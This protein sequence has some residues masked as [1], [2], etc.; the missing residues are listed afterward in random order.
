MNRV[1]IPPI[2]GG[3][4]EGTSEAAQPANT[5]ID[6]ENVRGIDARSGRLMW[7]AQRPGLERTGEESVGSGEFPTH[8]FE[9]ER[10]ELRERW[11]NLTTTPAADTDPDSVSF[12]WDGPG[13]SLG[14][15]AV[16]DMTSGLEGMGYYLLDTGEVVLVNA[17]GAVSERVPGYVPVGMRP[18]PR[19]AVDTEG[20]IFLAA[21][22]DEALIE[23]EYEG[24]ASLV[25]RITKD[26][27]DIWSQVWETRFESRMGLFGYADGQM[28]LVLDAPE[29][30]EGD[31]PP[32]ELVR[33]A[34]PLATGSVAWRQGPV[35]RPVLDVTIGRG[36]SCLLSCPSSPLRVGPD[37][38]EFTVRTV[39]W[40]PWELPVP[41]DQLYAWV[42]A[43]AVNDSLNPPEDGAAVTVMNDRRKLANPFVEIGGPDRDMRRPVGLIFDAPVWDATAFG[44]LGGVKFSPN[45]ALRSGRNVDETI[46]GQRALIPAGDGWGF[47]AVVQLDEA[48]IAGAAPPYGLMRQAT[49][50]AGQ[51]SLL[52][53]QNGDQLT[54]GDDA[55][56][57]STSVADVGTASAGGSRAAIISLHFP[58]AGG[59]PAWRING[60]AML[61]GAAWPNGAPF[62]PYSVG[63]VTAATVPGPQTV[64]GEG[65][66]N[67]RDLVKL[68]QCTLSASASTQGS[69]SNVRD[70]NVGTHVFLNGD[71]VTAYPYILV[72]LTSSA[73]NAEGIDTIDL[74]TDASAV[75]VICSLDGDAPTGSPPAPMSATFDMEFALNES[76][77]RV[78]HGHNQGYGYNLRLPSTGIPVN[79]RY[80]LLRFTPRNSFFTR[81]GTVGVR[82]QSLNVGTSPATWTFWGACVLTTGSIGN[83][84]RIEGYF[85]RKVGLL[86]ELTAYAPTHPYRDGQPWPAAGGEIVDPGAVREA[87]RSPFPLL[88]KWGADGSPVAAEVSAGVGLGAVM[89]PTGEAVLTVGEPDPLTPGT[90]PNHGVMARKLTDEGRSFANVWGITAGTEI[91]LVATTRLTTG[92]CGSLFFPFRPGP[93]STGSAAV[94]RYTSAG[95]L[96]WSLAAPLLPIALAPGGLLIDESAL[97][98]A[99]G[100]EFLFA[101]T[102]GGP[103]A[104]RVEVTGRVDTGVPDAVIVSRLAVTSAGLIRRL[105]ADGSTWSTVPGGT[106]TGPRPWSERIYGL[107]VLGDGRRYLVYDEANDTLRD[108]SASVKGYLPPRAKLALAHR[109]RLYLAAADNPFALYASRYGDVFDWDLGPIVEDVAQAVAG[110]TSSQGAVP[111]RI[112]A[113][114]PLTDDVMLVGT[115]RSLYALTGDLGEGGRLDLVDRSNGVAFGYAWCIGSRGLYYFSA[116]GGVWLRTA[117]GAQL[118]SAGRIQ[119]RLEDVDQRLYRIELGYRWQDRTVHVFVIPVTSFVED[120]AHYV[121]EEATG[122]WHIDR[123]AGGVGRQVTCVATLRGG[124]A[125]ERT[126]AMG[127][128]DGYV[129]E[130]AAWAE[131]DDGEPI[132]SRALLGPLLPPSEAREGHIRAFYG[133]LASDQGSVEVGVRAGDA[134]DSPGPL[135][136]SGVLEPG[137]GYGV[138]ARG[139]GAALFVEVSGLGRAWAIHHLEADAMLLGEKGARQ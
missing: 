119:R 28:Y 125:Q 62:G 97:G 57:A 116:S 18:V 51:A 114:M 131:D 101:A 36:G 118:V 94:R 47:V 12:G 134:L 139:A 102:V 31:R 50:A 45:S 49:T 100:P 78:D 95:A 29:P 67:D 106:L 115:S 132:S 52:L 77:P 83:I 105:S 3:L 5:Y 65:D 110:T 41:L 117:E 23:G 39:T 85:A 17:A 6:G 4:S 137:R 128:V 8:L 60:L 104:H 133:Q 87:M 136:E 122:A 72:D 19:I 81:V 98:G 129:R 59:A 43:D 92:P 40:T 42:E 111:E 86:H 24:A 35:P 96:S 64:F 79:A 88:L 48:T 15:G 75:Q 91:P 74:V 37:G 26:S 135:L 70:G 76:V 14:S 21:T 34:S 25:T 90:A 55:I 130:L 7:G 107:T 113:L 38:T 11:V 69:L 20:G 13:T 109:G 66:P 68:A 73:T 138:T 103:R 27:A 53:K 46:E 124:A 80:V 112:S 123:F 44:G 1:Q 54:A 93:G 121:L 61:P 108:F 89:D 56:A 9:T 2:A 33:M 58:T 71:N 84:E 82:A 16:L 99:C 120:I 32:S 63:A 10:V 127:F 22:A 126:L 30:E